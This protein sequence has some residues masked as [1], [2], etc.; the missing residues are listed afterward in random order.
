MFAG[1]GRAAAAS[2]P[3]P[4]AGSGV[5]VG[6]WRGGARD[7][8]CKPKIPKDPGMGTGGQSLVSWFQPSTSSN[9]VASIVRDRSSER[10]GDSH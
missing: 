7:S 5:C 2:F 9:L 6:Y 10:M 8:G 3:E 4:C 1:P